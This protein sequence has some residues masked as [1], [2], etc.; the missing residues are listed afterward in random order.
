VTI[1]ADT[2][3]LLVLVA[4]PFVLALAAHAL[5]KL[6]PGFLLLSILGTTAGGIALTSGDLEV[7][8]QLMGIGGVV[9]HAGA[10]SGWFYLTSASVFGGVLFYLI[11]RDQ[12]ARLYAHL[13]YLSGG[14]NIA[15]VAADL[16]SLY[17]AVEF[18]TIVSLLLMMSDGRPR[19]VWNGVRYLFINNLAML[20]YLIGAAMTYE[21]AGTFA[22][23]AIAE[24]PAAAQVLLVMAMLVKGGIFISGLWLPFAHGE[25]NTAV[26][27][28]L[29]GVVVKTGVYPLLLF[30]AESPDLETLLRYLGAASAV[31]GVVLAVAEKDT[32]RLLAF[33]TVSQLGFILAAPESGG[34][35]ALGHG[36]VKSCLFLLA[37]SLHSRSLKQLR[38]DGISA[39]LWFPLLVASLSISGMPGFLGY[40][41]KSLSLEDMTDI[42]FWAMSAASVGTCISFAKFIFLPVRASFD[43]DRVPRAAS[44][45]LLGALLGGGLLGGPFTLAAAGKAALV[46]TIGWLAY[47]SVFQFV[48]VKLPRVAERLE[49]LAGA[50]PAVALLLYLG[51]QL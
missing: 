16:F 42:L 26:S 51:L 15:F 11:R 46:L 30:A 32:K 50:L 29:S 4:G 20:F 35:Y 2:A 49:H 6:A 7:G 38:H 25:A 1:P 34:L 3:A 14:L 12:P 47:L 43:W 10:L 13:L 48:D 36:L 27:A 39:A 33:H 18:V 22:I 5:P 31:G 23:A 28:L 40:T 24:A 41:A 21:H 19:S 44:V 9:W 45:F 17:V 8:G 37:G